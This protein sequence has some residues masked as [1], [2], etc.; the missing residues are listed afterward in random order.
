MLNT[1]NYSTELLC[2]EEGNILPLK[3]QTCY[4][5]YEKSAW[6]LEDCYLKCY[7][8]SSPRELDD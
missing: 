7:S 4:G 1:L 6:V 8:L 3:T 5:I 2:L